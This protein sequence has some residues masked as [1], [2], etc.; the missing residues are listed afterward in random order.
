[1]TRLRSAK[2]RGVP[3]APHC[4]G[5]PPG[6]VPATTERTSLSRHDVGRSR[7]ADPRDV[8]HCLM[9]WRLLASLTPAEQRLVLA[10]THRHRYAKGETLFHEGDLAETIHLIQEGRV[11]AR[12]STPQGD[13]VTYSVMGPGEAFG[14]MAMLADDHR[15]S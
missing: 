5:S 4:G 2:C 14:E 9:E 1:M 3:D 10:R 8:V 6:S 7:C 15:R 11:V 13:V 12:R